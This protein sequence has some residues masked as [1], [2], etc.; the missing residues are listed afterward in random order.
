VADSKDLVARLREHA[1]DWNGEQMPDGEPAKGDPTAGLMR[2][3][4]AEIEY[5][6]QFKVAYEEYEQLTRWVQNDFAAGR[7]PISAAGKHRAT[8]MREMIERLTNEYICTCGLRVEP[9]RCRRS[10]D[11]R[12]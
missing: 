8:I 6:G 4:A 5:L 1:T 3:A 7:I 9:H 12:F 10:D 2:E 11:P